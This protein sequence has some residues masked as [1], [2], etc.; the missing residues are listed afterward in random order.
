[1]WAGAEPAEE[2]GG[3]LST[4]IEGWAGD[5]SGPAAGCLLIIHLSSHPDEGTAGLKFNFWGQ[6]IH[7][8][9]P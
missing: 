3:G 2:E 6:K 5:T 4:G 7:H 9:H 1:M 8:P